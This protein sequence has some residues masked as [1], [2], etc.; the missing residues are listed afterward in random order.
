MSDEATRIRL[1]QAFEMA[2]LGFRLMRQTL[3]RRFPNATEAAIDKKYAKWI[4]G[5][6]LISGTDLKVIPLRRPNRKT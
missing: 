3:R 2:E 1:R 6:P 4:T 5:C